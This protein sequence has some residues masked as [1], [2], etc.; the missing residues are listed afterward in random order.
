MDANRQ[1][2]IAIKEI[3]GTAY[4]YYGETLIALIVDPLIERASLTYWRHALHHHPNVI[5]PDILLS[6]SHT[7]KSALERRYTDW[8]GV[9]DESINPTNHPCSV[10]PPSLHV[11]SSGE[12]ERRMIVLRNEHFSQSWPPHHLHFNWLRLGVSAGCTHDLQHLTRSDVMENLHH[13]HEYD[14]AYKIKQIFDTIRLRDS[15]GEGPPLHTSRAQALSNNHFWDLCVASH[16]HLFAPIST[17]VQ[18]PSSAGCDPPSPPLPPPTHTPV[19]HRLRDALWRSHGCVPLPVWQPE[20]VLSYLKRHCINIS[21]TRAEMITNV[22]IWIGAFDHS[23]PLDFFVTPTSDAGSMFMLRKCAKY[24]P[25]RSCPSHSL[26]PTIISH[27][28][29]PTPSEQAYRT[30]RFSPP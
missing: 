2:R 21:T 8:A 28:L 18:P 22:L 30:T 23:K 1:E 9:T 17:N 10:L 14:C 29:S 3:E 15:Q 16:M 19:P 24:N 5:V 25:T 26:H 13:I 20:A 4:N 27:T 12:R 11:L 7:L 6:N